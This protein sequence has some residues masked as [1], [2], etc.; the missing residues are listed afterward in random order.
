MST[1]FSAY[2]ALAD[3]EFAVQSQEEY[4]FAQ[5][6]C[7]MCIEQTCNKDA[8]TTGLIGFSTNHGAVIRWL[9]TQHECSAIT[10]KC[11]EMAGKESQA[12]S[13]KDLDQ[14]RARCD[15]QDVEAVG[16]TIRS[17]VNPFE[18]EGNESIHLSSGVV[19]SNKIQQDLL[20]AY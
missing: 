11:K 12:R 8:H 19:A 6:E 16:N 7:D 20:E 3:G 14:T 13:R 4:G 18:V 1:Y 17:M 15:E 9:F 2:V 10:N 5:I